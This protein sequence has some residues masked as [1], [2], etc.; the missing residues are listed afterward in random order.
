GAVHCASRRHDRGE[1]TAVGSCARGN[2]LLGLPG[3]DRKCDRVSS[4]RAAAVLVGEADVEGGTRLGCVGIV[5]GKRNR[6]AGCAR[7]RGVG[8][9]YRGLPDV[10]TE[11]AI[12]DMGLVETSLRRTHKGRSENPK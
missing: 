4:A 7:R 8:Q 5:L 2:K 10:R 12:R 3:T 9:E 11:D 1:S 6:A